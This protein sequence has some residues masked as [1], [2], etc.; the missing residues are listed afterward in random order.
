[1]YRL[2]SGWVRPDCERLISR[3][4]ACLRSWDRLSRASVAMPEGTGVYS[5]D[6]VNAIV[7][8]VGTLNSRFGYSGEDAPQAVFSSVR[9]GMMT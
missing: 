9:I 7:G 4:F 2:T 1:M 3:L 8:D 5:G 6:D